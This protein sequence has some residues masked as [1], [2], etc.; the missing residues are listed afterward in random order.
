[1][2]SVI[3]PVHNKLPH[4]ERSI[5]S[6]LKQSI[7]DFELLLI[8]D[9]STDGS[10]E[11]LSEFKD[12][13]IKRFRREVPGPG[14][15][16]ARNLGIENAKYDWI[17]FLDADDKWE[18]HHLED[19]K[20]AISKF[21]DVNIVS[22]N[23][24]ISKNGIHSGVKEL[25]KFTD[26]Y[27]RFSLIDFFYTKSL[28]W[29]GAVAIRK[30]LIRNVGMFPAGKCKRGGDMDTWIRSLYKST[31]NIFINTPSVTYYRDIEGQV[32]D[33]KTN[34]TNRI[35]AQETLDQ[36]RAEIKDKDLLVAI[37]SYI[38][39]FVYGFMLRILKEDKVIEIDRLKHIYT[40]KTRIKILTKLYIYRFLIFFKFK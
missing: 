23:W 8:D 16:A 28:M 19:I 20:N 3:I 5:N 17:A 36:I 34:P 24:I 39:S 38:G 29:T 33:N 37:D 26:L 10:S 6:V 14:G 11:K 9:A 4:L 22:T 25:K 12:P 35:C 31:E 1:M 13:R 27:T 2:F 7:E 15:Y 40:Q 32:T 18:T 30:Q 21:N